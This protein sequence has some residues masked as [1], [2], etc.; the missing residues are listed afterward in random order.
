MRGT[1]GLPARAIERVLP[2]DLR[3]PTVYLVLALTLNGPREKR[4][5]K[6]TEGARI[7]RFLRPL[8]IA[9]QSFEALRLNR[10]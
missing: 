5:A 1:D 8:Q 4:S 7:L 6:K 10:A 2:E 9:P 3:M